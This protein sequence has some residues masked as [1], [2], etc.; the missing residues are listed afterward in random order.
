MMIRSFGG[1]GMGLVA[2]LG[3]LLLLVGIVAVGVLIWALTK[4]NGKKQQRAEHPTE[5][6]A[7]RILRERYARGEITREQFENMRRDLGA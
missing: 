3:A 6:S 7:L 4:P 2:A 1:A 5:D